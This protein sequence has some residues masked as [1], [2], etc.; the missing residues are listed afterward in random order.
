[1]SYQEDMR[2]NNKELC[3]L[4]HVPST[5]VLQDGEVCEHA[6]R[7]GEITVCHYLLVQQDVVSDLVNRGHCF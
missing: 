1:M 4:C 7:F 5:G 6:E 2:H 3:V